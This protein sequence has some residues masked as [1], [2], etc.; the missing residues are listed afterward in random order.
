V[1]HF[2]AKFEECEKNIPKISDLNRFAGSP[3]YT[4]R[5][6]LEAE[7]KMLEFFRWNVNLPTA[8]HFYDFYL[9]K[10]VAQDD[11]YNG[12]CLG[13]ETT[14]AAVSMS[15]YVVYFLEVSLQGEISFLGE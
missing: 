2:I 3:G 6:Y 15:K 8:A 7:V 11:V 9:V 5:Q 12:R 10:A 1:F 4:A 14:P 13:D